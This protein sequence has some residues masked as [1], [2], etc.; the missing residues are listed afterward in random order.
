MINK[1]LFFE[2]LYDSG[3]H[4]KQ[5]SRHTGV[6]KDKDRPTF[7]VPFDNGLCSH[8]LAGTG[9]ALKWNPTHNQYYCFLPQKND[10]IAVEEWERSQGSR[11][12]IR[13]LLSSTIALDLNFFDNESGIKTELG[14]LEQ[15]AKH[16]ADQTAIAALAAK[17]QETINANF[18]F[19]V[20]HGG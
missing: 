8:F 18:P 5:F 17:S 15:K 4:R 10:I 3:S 11:V 6:Q 16:D 12:F 20:C 14:V 19:D 9:K 7:S 2:M 13:N 1:E